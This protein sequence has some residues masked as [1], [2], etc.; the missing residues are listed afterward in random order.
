LSKVIDVGGIK[1]SA[2][3]DGGSPAT[4]VLPGARLR[5]HPDLL[6]A[7]GTYHFPVGCFLIQA[8]DL[9]VLMDAGMTH[10]PGL[11]LQRIATANGREWT[12]AG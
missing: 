9:T 12:T 5:R 6:Q 3:N 7:D 4:H 11:D 2:L 1:I 10:F 8:E